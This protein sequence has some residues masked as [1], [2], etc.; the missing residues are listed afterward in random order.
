[1]KRFL[2]ILLSLVMVC[3]CLAGCGN[4]DSEKH[5]ISDLYSLKTEFVGDN[6]KVSGIVHSQEYD[7]DIE[8]ADIEIQSEKEPYGLNINVKVEDEEVGKA[9]LFNNAVID[10]ALIGNLSE[11]DFVNRDNKDLIAH[12]SRDEVDS[13]LK[14][15][16]YPSIETIGAS[17]ENLLDYINKTE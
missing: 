4:E 2:G 10:F 14:E 6:S 5:G 15:S 17:E 8:P 1:M 16:G 13:F 9:D 3:V 12:F 11:I 7:D